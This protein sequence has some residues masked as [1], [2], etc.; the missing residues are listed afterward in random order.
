MSHIY[1]NYYEYDDNGKSSPKE[2]HFDNWAEYEEFSAKVKRFDTKGSYD[3]IKIWEA[4]SMT[5]VD[6]HD[7]SN[8]IPAT[9]KSDSWHCECGADLGK[10]PD[11][12]T[13]CE[14]GKYVVSRISRWTR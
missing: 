8:P 9:L 6:D 4:V 11:V 7:Y 2:K 10:K 1:F 12:G 3:H 13:M 14:C 5:T